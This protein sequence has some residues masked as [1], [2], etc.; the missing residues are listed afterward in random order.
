MPTLPLMYAASAQPDRRAAHALGD[1]AE[2]GVVGHHHGQPHLG[3]EP[4]AE[5]GVDPAQVG[6]EPHHPVAGPHRAGHRDA[7]AEAASAARRW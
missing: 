6:T 3:G 5:R 2:V 4:L 7:D 1:H